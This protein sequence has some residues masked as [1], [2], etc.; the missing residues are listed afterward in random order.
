MA[1]V[2]RKADPEE[3]ARLT[4]G[5]SQMRYPGQ[6]SSKNL[7]RLLRVVG[8]CKSVGLF[9]DNISSVRRYCLIP[10]LSV[11]SIPLDLGEKTGIGL[12]KG[13]KKSTR[14]GD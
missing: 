2:L 8:L 11:L 10:A 13:R 5:E 4:A 14:K 6:W 12:A 1:G 9:Y 7:Q 3:Y